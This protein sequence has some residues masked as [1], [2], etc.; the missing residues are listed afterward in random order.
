M[1]ETTNNYK[2]MGFFELLTIIFVIAKILGY[3]TWSWY[4]VFAPIAVHICLVIL[5]L[6]I[7]F[8]LCFIK[9][10]LD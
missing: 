1:A 7:V 3:I 2:F 5:V 6:G 9:A 8:S 4:L 10:L